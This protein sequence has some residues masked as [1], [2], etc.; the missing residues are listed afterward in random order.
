MSSL[1]KIYFVCQTS[2]SNDTS[3]RYKLHHTRVPRRAGSTSKPRCYRTTL[4]FFYLKGNPI[5]IL[6]CSEIALV[7]CVTY[8]PWGQVGGVGYQSGSRESHSFLTLTATSL[9]KSISAVGNESV[10]FIRYKTR[11]LHVC[12]CASSIVKDI[13]NTVASSL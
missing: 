4:T 11:K 10:T 7:T 5:H 12:H 9:K 3:I 13:S 1:C 2:V 6:S 8:L